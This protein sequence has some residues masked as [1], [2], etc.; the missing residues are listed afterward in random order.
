MSYTVWHRK[1]RSVSQAPIEIMDIEL[2][3]WE[4]G[5]STRTS[6]EWVRGWGVLLKLQYS[7]EHNYSILASSKHWMNN[8]P[9]ILNL[10]PSLLQPYCEKLPSLSMEMAIFR[11][12][13]F[14][15]K[16]TIWIVSVLINSAKWSGTGNYFSGS[17]KK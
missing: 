17:N 7:G 14:M 12:L 6:I 10:T 2:I 13:I 8:I 11:D 16:G 4:K 3:H 9:L 1:L 5:C 15:L